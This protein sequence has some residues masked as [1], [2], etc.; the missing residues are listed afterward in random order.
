MDRSARAGSGIGDRVEAGEFALTVESVKDCPQPYVKEGN[1]VIGVEVVVEGLVEREIQVNP[2]YGQVVDGR[3][4]AVRPTFKG[5]EPRLK[6]V[7]L[8]QGESARGFINF[9]LPTSSDQLELKY[10]PAT[11]GGSRQVVSVNL[12]R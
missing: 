4:L 5:C 8:D 2:F 3:G 7:R 10:E 6:N 11:N 1:T 12:D 9:E